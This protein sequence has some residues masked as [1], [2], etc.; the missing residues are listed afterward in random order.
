MTNLY[1]GEMTRAEGKAKLRR[2]EKRLGLDAGAVTIGRV[3]D[4]RHGIALSFTF[5]DIPI[6]RSC[7]SQPTQ[8]KNLACLVIWLSDLVRNIERRIETF[9]E[10]FYSEGAKLLPAQADLY[11]DTKPNLYDGEMTEEEALEK[12]ERTLH[13]LSMT[14]D[15][16][17]VRWFPDTGAARLRMRLSSG[18][19]VEKNSTQQEDAR[20]NLCALA[21]WLQTRAKNYERGIETDLNRLSAANLLPR[22]SGD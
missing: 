14:R 21:L 20:T 8:A 12:I 16:I 4:S 19:V 11:A 13:R 1:R 10:A 3:G 7:D 2:L 22:S 18:H 6:S 5:Q 15:D 17:N 9:G